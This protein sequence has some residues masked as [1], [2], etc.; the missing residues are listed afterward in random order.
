MLKLEM[1]YSYTLCPVSKEGESPAWI[2]AG[3]KVQQAHLGKCCL[4]T[5]LTDAAS[6][7]NH[8]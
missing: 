1:N 5:G 8:L 2:K 6:D 7:L 3:L 4:S